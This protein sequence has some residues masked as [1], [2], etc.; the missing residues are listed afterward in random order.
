MGTHILTFLF[1]IFL[2]RAEFS[3]G[4]LDQLV[5]GVYFLSSPSIT[6]HPLWGTQEAN[7]LYTATGR[8]M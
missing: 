6:F 7:F 3:H 2:L 8:D 5:P 4:H 1:Q